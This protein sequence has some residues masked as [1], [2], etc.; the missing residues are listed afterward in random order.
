[1]ESDCLY[2]ET[3]KFIKNS[4]DLCELILFLAE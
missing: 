3:I 1:M 4:G 2:I